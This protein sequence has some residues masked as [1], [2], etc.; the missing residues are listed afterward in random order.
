[1]KIITFLLQRCAPNVGAQDVRWSARRD[2]SVFHHEICLGLDCFWLSAVPTA[3]QR[4]RGS[5]ESEQA[6]LLRSPCLRFV[7]H[8]EEKK[9]VFV[10]RWILDC[11]ECSQDFTHSEISVP[12]KPL[13][14]FSWLGSKPDFPDEGITFECPHCKKASVYK[15]H[16]LRYRAV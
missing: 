4:T 12:G 16:Q 8:I 6:L 7:G 2:P 11:P 1:M 10:A 3:V 15:R 9:E 13:D 14:A 5:P